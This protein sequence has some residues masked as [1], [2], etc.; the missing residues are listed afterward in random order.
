M[1]VHPATAAYRA[2]KV[3]IE[4]AV[5]PTALYNAAKVEMNDLCNAKSK[6]SSFLLYLRKTGT[7]IQVHFL[8]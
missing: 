8:I 1:K 3:C 4:D 6:K 7:R 5:V 2:L